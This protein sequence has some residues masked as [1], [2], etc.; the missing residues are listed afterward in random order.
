MTIKHQMK[1][2]KPSL[3]FLEDRNMFAGDIFANPVG[4]EATVN[5]CHGNHEFQAPVSLITETHVTVVGGS[6]L[7]FDD[8]LN[9]NGNTLNKSGDGDMEIGN[10]LF[11]TATDEDQ[12]VTGAGGTLNVHGG[13][14]SGNGIVGGEVNNYGGTI[15]PGRSS[16]LDNG[17]P[18][19]IIDPEAVNGLAGKGVLDNGFPYGIID[20]EAVNGLAEVHILD[21]GFPHGIIDPEALN[22]LAEVRVL[23]NGF[24][25]GIIDPEALNGLAEVRVLDNGF[26]HGIIDPEA[27]SREWFGR[28]TCSG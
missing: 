17:F 21:N 10:D 6:T 23:D 13:V 14:V 16:V 7:R 28:G 18:Y 26:P 15:S 27:G 19:G 1:N 24:P 5:V 11:G 25:Y 12:R 4:T 8:V 22:G 20:P 3:E 2:R 9:L